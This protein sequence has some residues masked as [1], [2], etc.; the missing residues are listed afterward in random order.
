MITDQL[1]KKAGEFAMVAQLPLSFYRGGEHQFGIWA[2]GDD[3]IFR[4]EF[5]SSKAL[6]TGELHSVSVWETGQVLDGAPLYTV[7]ID[8]DARDNIDAIVSAIAGQDAPLDEST[9]NRHLREAVIDDVESFLADTE[10]DPFGSI[11]VL[12]KDYVLYATEQGMSVPSQVAFGNAIRKL[13]GG[14]ANTATSSKVSVRRGVA[15]D[16]VDQQ[17]YDDFEQNVLNSEILL[18][19]EMMHEVYKRVVTWDP[20]YKN[21]FIYGVGGVGKSYGLKKVIEKYANPDEIKIYKGTVSG[22]TG[23]LQILWN[24]RTRKIIVLDDNDTVLANDAAVNI[25][26]SAMDSDEPRVISYTRL[27]KKKKESDKGI[28][29]DGSKLHENLITIEVDGETF[30]ERVNAQEKAFYKKLEKIV[31]GKETH[32]SAGK[33][34]YEDYDDGEEDDYYDDDFEGGDLDP[35]V[36]PAYGLG[37]DSEVPDQFQFTSRVIF[38]SNLLQ[39]PQ[40]ILD[41]TISVGLFLSKEQIL[42][43]IESLLDNILKEEAPEVTLETKKAALSFMRKYVHRINVPLTFRFF[44]K[45][46]AFFHNQETNPKALE[47]AYLAMRGDSQMKTKL[48]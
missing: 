10:A 16:V 24:N 30:T 7:E 35:D 23:M 12:F 21:V 48:R 14:E 17:E 6:D 46:C 4:Y 40:P 13:R 32:E 8:G 11:S 19:Y 25:L 41:R 27:K 15:D 47:M 42:D 34:L 18:K 43:L 39:V 45:M 20:L 38:I 22:F 31:E 33:T 36:D 29:I 28:F 5:P 44:G 9:Y 2:F 26:K 37:P 1:D 3:H